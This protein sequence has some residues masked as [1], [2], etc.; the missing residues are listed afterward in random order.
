LWA[1]TA[2]PVAVV[3]AVVVG[4]VSSLWAVNRDAVAC[5]SLDELEFVLLVFWFWLLNMVD[6]QIDNA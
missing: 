3:V 5:S 4:V 6:N 2:A 1:A